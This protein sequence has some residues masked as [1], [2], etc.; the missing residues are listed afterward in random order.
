MFPFLVLFYNAGEHNDEAGTALMSAVEV[1]E[2]TVT[3]GEIAVPRTTFLFTS[4][5]D[6]FHSCVFSSLFC[7][8]KNSAIH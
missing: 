2:Q 6:H 4:G 8:A 3:D 7:S 5:I 1:P